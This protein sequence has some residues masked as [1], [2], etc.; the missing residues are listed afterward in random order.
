MLLNT[1]DAVYV[2]AVP[3][4]KVYA[5]TVLVWSATTSPALPVTAGLA[6]WFDA[7]DVSTMSFSSGQKVSQWR[8]KSG[9]A[10]HFGQV[11]T[12]KQ[13]SQLDAQN[14]LPTLSFL[15]SPADNYMDSIAAFTV[16]QP[17]TVFMAMDTFADGTQGW[18]SSVGGNLQTFVGAGALSLYAGDGV[19]TASQTPFGRHVWS[20]AYDGPSSKVAID[21]AAPVT[22][23]FTPGSSGTTTGW[24]LAE[25]GLAAGYRLR[26]EVCEVIVY[27]R[28]LTPAEYLE[29]NTYLANKWALYAALAWMKSGE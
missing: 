7:S 19:R 28:I 13:P 1:A 22:L 5:G 12:T 14:G 11:D 4:D 27:D 9:L 29:V 23:T 25:R 24:R 21:G 15:Q 26:G 8:D 2:G 17:F 16:P 10:R 3:A 18:F 6:G 20:F